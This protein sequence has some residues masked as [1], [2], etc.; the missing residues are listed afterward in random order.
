MKKQLNF[1]GFLRVLTPREAFVRFVVNSG[2]YPSRK[3]VVVFLLFFVISVS[4][5]FVVKAVLS[6]VII[7]IYFLNNFVSFRFF[8]FC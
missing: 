5:S 8:L 3:R 7:L 1:D 4:A 2:K 6:G